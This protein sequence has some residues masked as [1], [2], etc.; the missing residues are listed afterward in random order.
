M[1]IVAQTNALATVAVRMPA[2]GVLTHVL[3]NTN[4]LISA[5]PTAVLADFTAPAAAGLRS[6]FIFY[7]SSNPVQLGVPV[8]AG[9]VLY[10]AFAA[11]GSAIL[12]FS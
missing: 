4:V 1:R 5:N 6:D 7:G 11:A 8:E 3:C 10:C 12:F 2:K 9:E